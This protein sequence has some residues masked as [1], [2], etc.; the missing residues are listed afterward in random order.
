MFVDKQCA[1]L[2]QQGRLR[3]ELMY[4]AKIFSLSSADEFLQYLTDLGESAPT[5][6]QS[7]SNEIYSAT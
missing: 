3:T 6:V 1:S 7:Y 5:D 2:L 4:K